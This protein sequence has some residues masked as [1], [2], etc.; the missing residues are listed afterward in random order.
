MK[1]AIL[2]TAVLTLVVVGALAIVPSGII[3][4]DYESLHHAKVSGAIDQGWVPSWL[5]QSAK[6]IH[7]SQHPS[8]NAWYIALEYGDVDRDWFSGPCTRLEGNS[9]S[10]PSPRVD[11]WFSPDQGTDGWH[12]LGFFICSNPSTGHELVLALDKNSRRAFLWAGAR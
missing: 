4:S 3:E 12:S 11:W 7:Q 8:S 5:P 10:N 1:V 6:R 9:P 2:A